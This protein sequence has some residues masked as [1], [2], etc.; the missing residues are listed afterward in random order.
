VAS[1]AYVDPGNFASNFGG[2]AEFGY[3]FVWVI[4]MANVMA[5]LAQYCAAKVGLATSRTLPE[6]CRT[7]Y[8]RRANGVL[9]VQG[10]LVAMATDLAEFVG[11]A[12]GLNLLFGVPL[13][14]AGLVTAVVAF[15]ILSLEQR[16]YRK[17]EVAIAALLLLVLGGFLFQV[18]AVGG[19]S[20]TAFVGGLVPRVQGANQATLVVAIIGAT[21]M[22]HVVYLHSA[23]FKSRPAPADE[24]ERQRFLRLNRLD[25]VLGLGLAGLVNLSMLCIAA[26]LFFVPGRPAP[27]DLDD[28]HAF[29]G[30]AVG[31]GAAAAFAIALTASGLASASVGTYAGQVVMSGFLDVRIN[32]MLRRA[33]TMVP[34]LLVLAVA[35]DTASVLILSQVVLSFG[36]PFALVPLTMISSDQRIMG[37][38]VNRRSTTVLMWTITTVIGAL[39]AYLVVAFVVALF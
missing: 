39:N 26:A 35:R 22:P 9:W 27:G 34:A 4:V 12:V 7:R 32:L 31:A 10:E 33:I 28:I 8:G 38:M 2:G 25:C 18:L 16:G 23:L 24:A 11:A 19:Q 21:V 1:V 3:R 37:T 29:L 6:V 15:A 5:I 30:A 13:L 14:Q 36:I 17:F 20:G